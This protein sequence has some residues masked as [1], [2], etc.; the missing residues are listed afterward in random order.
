MPLTD[1]PVDADPLAD[2][3]PVAR[4]IVHAAM[5]LVARSGLKSF[6]LTAVTAEAGVYADSIRYYF[7]GIGGVLETIVSSL[8]HATSIRAMESLA[9]ID[10]RDSR[11]Q[12]LAEAGRDIAGE[13]E[14]Y[15]V[16]WEVVPRV[17][18]DEV[19]RQR[20]AKEYEWYR[21]LY[22]RDFPERPS[23]LRHFS[24]HERA[25]TLASL[26]VAMIDG[27]ALQKAIDPDH[28]DLAVAFSMWAA[29]ASP[30]LEKSSRCETNR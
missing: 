24:D 20:M 5:D 1:F 3:P 18:G 12:A 13:E 28:V 16:F 22:L 17:L 19:W 7:G 26:M 6:T 23:E 2:L 11:A 8:S 15:R 9:A 25:R 29:I 4:K 30:A 27:L 14:E 10:E 21:E